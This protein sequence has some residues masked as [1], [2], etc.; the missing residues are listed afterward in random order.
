MSDVI[1]ASNVVL[2][3]PNGG[4]AGTIYVLLIAIV[5]MF[6]ST[7]CEPHRFDTTSTK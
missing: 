6:F 5:G 2:T 7:L 4:K 1:R 3:L